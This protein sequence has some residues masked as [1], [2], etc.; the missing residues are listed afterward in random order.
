MKRRIPALTLAICFAGVAFSSAATAQPEPDDE[1]PTVQRRFAVKKSSAYLH[2]T[3]AT[4]IRNDFYDSFGVGGDIGFYPA[5]NFGL[6]LRVLY[7]D[8]RLSNAAIGVRE[9]TGLTPDARPQ[10][11]FATVGPRWSFG[12]GKLLTLGR[13]VL[14]FDPQLTAQAGIAVAERRVLPSAFVGPGLLV[15]LMWGIQVKIDLG[16][17]IQGEQRDRGWVVTGGFFPVLGLGWNTGYLRQRTA[18]EG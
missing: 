8:T 14:H 9:Q 1:R 13:W 10:S 15:H 18:E 12:Y 11:L 5:E 4:H 17:S 16:A 3:G 7:L 2:A 6:E